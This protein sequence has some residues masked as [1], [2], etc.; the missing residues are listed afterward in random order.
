MIII[1]KSLND[2][3]NDMYKKI[4]QHEINH[5]QLKDLKVKDYDAH[6]L[7]TNVI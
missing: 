2:A 6:I 5:Y 4:E 7:Y 3:L 1:K